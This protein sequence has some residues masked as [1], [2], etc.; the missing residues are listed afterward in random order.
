MRSLSWDNVQSH[1]TWLPY[2]RCC[3]GLGAA[4]MNQ[5]DVRTTIGQQLQKFRLPDL[6]GRGQ[7]LPDVTIAAEHG[8]RLL[9]LELPG[10][11]LA[12]AGPCLQHPTDEKTGKQ[13]EAQIVVAP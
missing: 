12:P 2:D 4:A 7:K 1:P 6:E 8:G 13:D 9:V 5:N 11:E 3:P 10:P